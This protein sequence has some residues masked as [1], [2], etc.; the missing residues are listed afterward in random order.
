MRSSLKS[1]KPK[2]IYPA[3]IIYKVTKARQGFTAGATAKVLWR[4]H[5]PN[6]NQNCHGVTTSLFDMGATQTTWKFNRHSTIFLSLRINTGT[7]S[8]TNGTTVS[9]Y[10]ITHPS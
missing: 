10:Q 9:L 5:V 4:G 6:R 7:T 3:F 2:D 1:F 8:G